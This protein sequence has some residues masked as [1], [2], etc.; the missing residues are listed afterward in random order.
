L[1]LIAPSDHLPRLYPAV[2]FNV[3]TALKDTTLPRGGGDNGLEPIAILKGTDVAY[4]TLCMQRRADLFGPDVEE[5]KPERWETWTPKSWQFIPFN[6]GPRICI[7]QQFAYTE[8]QYTLVRLFQR[9]ETV[10]EKMEG[11]KQELKAEVVITPAYPVMVA[12]HQAK[13]H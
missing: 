8:I 12:L 7:G 13:A 9:I 2:P 5:F 11:R 4:S 3:R 1:I 10:D 6:G